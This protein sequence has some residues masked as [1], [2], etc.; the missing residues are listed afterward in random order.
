[1]ALHRGAVDRAPLAGKICSP[2]TASGTKITNSQV[3]QIHASNAVIVRRVAALF[4]PE[5]VETLVPVALFGVPADWASLTGVSG[6]YLNHHA[7]CPGCLVLELLAQIKESPADS[8]IAL[9]GAYSLSCRSDTGQVLQ[10]K[11]GVYMVVFHE[12]L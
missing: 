2:A 10:H 3:M 7:A 9:P 8:H 1:M 6:V 5:Q 12:C 4:A 11:Q